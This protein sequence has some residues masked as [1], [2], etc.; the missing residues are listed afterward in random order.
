MNRTTVVEMVERE[1][2]GVIDTITGVCVCVCVCV[3]NLYI[4]RAE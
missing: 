1:G 3:C 2:Q 4:T